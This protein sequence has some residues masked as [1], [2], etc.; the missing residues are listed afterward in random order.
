M[1]LLLQAQVFL[2]HF[3]KE[4][5]IPIQSSSRIL[6]NQNPWPCFNHEICLIHQSLLDLRYSRKTVA[7]PALCALSDRHWSLSSQRSG[8]VLSGN[9]IPRIVDRRIMISFV[10]VPEFLSYKESETK[11]TAP[12]IHYGC[13]NTGN[14]LVLIFAVDIGTIPHPL[15]YS[16]NFDHWW[17]WDN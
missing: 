14:W 17:K 6:A 4:M 12:V 9:A 1:R 8:R 13:Q 16:W 3:C 15:P 5:L 2:V 7:T 10:L 11:G